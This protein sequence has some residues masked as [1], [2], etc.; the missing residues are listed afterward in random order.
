M[1][2]AGARENAPRGR[3]IDELAAAASAKVLWVRAPNLARARAALER[4]PQLRSVELDL[5]DYEGLVG[6]LADSGVL[7]GR[8]LARAV[9]R[10]PA[11]A[12]ALLAIDG[13]FEIVVDLTRET[14][15]W[16]LAVADPA[17]LALRQPTYERLTE[18][19]END[20]DLREFFLRFTHPI[21]VEGVP[22]CISGRAPRV[23]PRVLDAAMHD[24]GGR[25]EIFRYTRRYIL[26]DYRT[27]S[28]RC[29]SC[30]HNSSCDGM[31]VNFVRA[32]G[33]GVM[34]PIAATP[35]ISAITG[36]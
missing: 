27:K 10:S 3:T 34:E 28:L 21:P 20:V 29:G 30:V 24:E 32:H 8:T 7:A 6:A 12:E 19:A 15:P 23:R 26:E 11:Q 33:Y 1:M 9:V 22:S 4:F 14:A 17:R 16:L 13:S 2:S 31:H 36:S 5:D 25:L 18:A 35:G